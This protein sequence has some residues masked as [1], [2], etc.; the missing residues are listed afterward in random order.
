MRGET[1]VTIMPLF[2]RKES[3][4]RIALSADRANRMKRISSRL[5]S[6]T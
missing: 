6:L 3:S 4:A 2:S 1:S 5:A